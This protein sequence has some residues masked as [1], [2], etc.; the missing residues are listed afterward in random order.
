MLFRR[1]SNPKLH[2]YLQMA[3]S[4]MGRQRLQRL[5]LSLCKGLHLKALES[6]AERWGKRLNASKRYTMRIAQ[7]PKEIERRTEKTWAIFWGKTGIVLRRKMSI[8]AIKRIQTSYVFSVFNCGY[9]AQTFSNAVLD[10]INAFEMWYYR[11]ILRTSWKEY[12]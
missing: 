2:A 9:E 3:A 4:S 12:Y 11:R 8:N 6:C 1:E 5:P 10:M 7:S